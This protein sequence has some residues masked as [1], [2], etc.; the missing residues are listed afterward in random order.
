MNINWKL[1]GT[2][3]C[4]DVFAG[5][6]ILHCALITS[7][8]VDGSA[9]PS[10]PLERPSKE[11][12]KK[13][14][15]TTTVPPQRHKTNEHFKHLPQKCMFFLTKGYCPGVSIYIHRHCRRKNIT[16]NHH[17]PTVGPQNVPL[18]KSISRTTRLTK[19]ATKI[20]NMIIHPFFNS[21]PPKEV[22]QTQTDC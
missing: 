19:E 22:Q 6:G 3:F 2:K 16:T 10:E 1:N 21:S 7:L 15:Q 5:D 20:E 12:G 13:G 11:C 4:V 17:N 9:T 8:Q 18:C 14:V